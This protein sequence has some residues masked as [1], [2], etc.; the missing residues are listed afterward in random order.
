M[1]Q[2]M[3]SDTEKKNKDVAFSEKILNSLTLGIKVS[4]RSF[5]K[6]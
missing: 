4:V 5:R 3:Q 6:N 1:I 2:M